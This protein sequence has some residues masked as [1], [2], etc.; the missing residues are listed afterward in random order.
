[1]VRQNWARGIWHST[2][3][4]VVYENFC[5][6]QVWD[7]GNAVTDKRLA[8]AYVARKLLLDVDD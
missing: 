6:L 8:C 4:Q 5:L 7:K 2:D 1:M 3:L